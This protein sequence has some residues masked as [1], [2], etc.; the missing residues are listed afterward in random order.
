VIDWL[1]VLAPF[2]ILVFALVKLFPKAKR[3]QRLGPV[4]PGIVPPGAARRPIPVEAFAKA[5]GIPRAERDLAR[6]AD[7]AWKGKPAL[8]VLD[9]ELQSARLSSLSKDAVA[10]CIYDHAR[11]VAPGLEIPILRPRVT[12]VPYTGGAGQFHV[13]SAGFIEIRIDSR[14]TVEPAQLSAVLAHEICHH[15]AF[16]SSLG[17]HH[18]AAANERTTELLM[19]ICGLGELAQSGRRGNL[20]LSDFRTEGYLSFADI[21]FAR[22]WARRAWESGKHGMSPSAA[23][24]ANQT[25]SSRSRFSEQERE[26]LLDRYRDRYPTKSDAW[27]IDKIMIDQEQDLR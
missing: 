16:Q 26:R 13:D 23:R 1:I 20:D 4:R 19:F 18:N 24:A 14:Y 9:F 15:I 7:R 10:K 6:L 27:I 17:D 5:S 8:S 2:V 21:I 25:A 11:K 12:A 22:D 3:S